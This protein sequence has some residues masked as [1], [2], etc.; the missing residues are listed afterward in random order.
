MMNKKS[1]IKYISLL[2]IVIGSGFFSASFQGYLIDATALLEPLL[3]QI[4]N[5]NFGLVFPGEELQ[6]TFTV[7]LAQGYDYE[8]EYQISHSPKPRIDTPEER[9]YCKAH[10]TDYERCYPDLCSFLNEE[11]Q[12]DEGDT[13]ISALL[14]PEDILDT[15]LVNFIVP[16]IAGYVAQGYEGLTVDNSGMFG[17]DIEVLFIGEFPG[18]CGYK[19]FDINEDGEMDGDDYGLAGW[20][21]YLKQPLACQEGEEWADTVVSYNQGN[22]KDGSPVRTQ[23]SNP[24]AAKIGQ[25][26]TIESHFFSLGFGG[27]IILGFD[28]YI[29]NGPGDDIELVEATNETYPDEKVNVYVSQTGLVGSW[30][31][32]GD[33]S[34][35]SMIDLSDYSPSLT[36][37]KYIKL[38]DTTNP[39]FHGNTADAYDLDGVKA[40]NCAAGWQ[41]IDTQITDENG[42]Y[43]FGPLESGLYRVEE[44]LQQDWTNTTPLYQYVWFSEGQEIGVNFGNYEEWIPECTD[45]DGDGYFIEG[46]DCGTFDCNDNDY[47]VNPGMSELCDNQIDDDCDG[48]TDCDDSECIEDP[49][50]QASPP[51]ECTPDETRACDTGEL[52]ICASGSQTCSQNGFWGGCI[53]DYQPGTE[54]CDNQ[55][56][57]D[58]DGY[59]DGADSDCPTNGE[60]NGGGGGGGG[61]PGLIIFN[62]KIK[63]IYSDRVIISWFT[64]HKATSRII[65]DT[66]SGVFVFD[67][68]PDYGYAYSTVESDTP[69]NP[70]GVTYHEVEVTGLSPG[71]PYYFRVVSHA[72]PEKVGQ[73][74]GFT[75]PT[76]EEEEEEVVQPAEQAAPAGGE[77]GPLI[78]PAAGPAEEEEVVIEEEPALEEE[79][80]PEEVTQKEEEAEPGT[81]LAAIAGLFTGGNFCWILTLIITALIVLYILSRKKKK[82]GKEIDH[83]RRDSIIAIIILI[84]LIF[85]IKCYLL[86]IPIIILLIFLLKEKFSKNKNN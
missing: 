57:D 50:C 18:I 71:I 26:D 27:S 4:G 39:A 80:G 70:N 29:I 21:I 44:V 41:I 62:E 83:Y 22:R 66:S 15:W 84:I 30:I 46:G 75:L 43:C 48:D 7:E 58:C 10:P 74:L 9:L 34:K 82:L 69:A 32:L 49:I 23:R 73:E 79:A 12:E 24:E 45:N 38:V 54:I 76:E 77:V 52:G 65:Y 31:F 40:L 55:I 85:S 37:M 6:K 51:P 3:V 56:D 64:N 11:S 63:E 35:D 13:P 1:I 33:Y 78:G 14:S 17:C 86:I 61:P 19:F 16:P 36:W 47:Y 67:N 25:Y 42:H 2:A 72:S 28:N 5:L 68:P 8:A 60:I 53:A 81:F 59:I 20:T